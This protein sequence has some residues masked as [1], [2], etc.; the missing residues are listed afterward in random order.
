MLSLESFRLRMGG[1][2]T[3]HFSQRPSTSHDP[4]LDTVLCFRLECD[5]RAGAEIRQREERL[6]DAVDGRLLVRIPECDAHH[7]RRTVSSLSH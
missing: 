5:P 1:S 6:I 4:K 7:R 3:V 2:A